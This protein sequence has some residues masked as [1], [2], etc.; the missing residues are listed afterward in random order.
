MKLQAMAGE[1]VYTVI[2][3]SSR[4]TDF[5]ESWILNYYIQLR[6]V[7]ISEH[8]VQWGHSEVTCAVSQFASMH[9]QVTAGSD[10]LWLWES[11]AR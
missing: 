5:T 3:D 8:S 1:L 4:P 10:H 11:A 2:F 9:K 7:R 6:Y